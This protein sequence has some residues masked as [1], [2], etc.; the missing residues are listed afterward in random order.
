[1]L[2]KD[3]GCFFIALVP[4]VFHAKHKIVEYLSVFAMRLKLLLKLAPDLLLVQ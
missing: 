4:S 2:V 1:M 3:L